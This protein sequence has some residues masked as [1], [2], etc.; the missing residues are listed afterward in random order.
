[1]CT[2]VFA[3]DITYLYHVSRGHRQ[4]RANATA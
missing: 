3:V 2:G 4:E 1:M